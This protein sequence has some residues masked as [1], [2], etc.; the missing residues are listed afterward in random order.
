MISSPSLKITFSLTLP[1]PLQSA[2]MD[3]RSSSVWSQHLVQSTLEQS[4]WSPRWPSMSADMSSSPVIVS[5]DCEFLEGCNVFSSS[6]YSPGFITIL[7]TWYSSKNACCMDAYLHL[8]VH[9]FVVTLVQN[10]ASLG[11]CS[12]LQLV[13][14]FY[15]LLPDWSPLFPCLRVQY[16][17][18]RAAALIILRQ[19]LD[20]ASALLQTSQ[21][22]SISANVKA[23]SSHRP[24]RLCGIWLCAAPSSLAPA[25]LLSHTVLRPQQ[26]LGY[27]SITSCQDPCFLCFAR[28]SWLRYLHGC[29]FNSM[30]SWL[31]HE[32]IRKTC[33]PSPLWSGSCLSQTP[34]TPFTALVFGISYIFYINF[35]LRVLNCLTICFFKSETFNFLFTAVSL[36]PKIVLVT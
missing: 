29:F 32:P 15:H 12:P 26:P 16:V 7:G 35:M 3:T 28:N 17:P 27:S 5:R 24:A 8:Q 11:Y 18:H 21:R 14:G 23:K 34:Y 10:S 4:Q 31:T 30:K 9:T 25:S 19:K 13:S 22:L 6:L 36:T 2:D 20:H 33:A 1:L